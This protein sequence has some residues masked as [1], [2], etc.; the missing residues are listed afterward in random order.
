MGTSFNH[1]LTR[2]TPLQAAIAHAIAAGQSISAAARSNGVGRTAIYSW[3][4]DSPSFSK[5]IEEA[6]QWYAETLGDQLRLLSVK[7]INTLDAIL[8]DPKTS[9]GV[10]LRAAAMIL[11]RKNWQLPVPVGTP[12][13]QHMEQAL[14]LA[15]ASYR[16]SKLVQ[17]AISQAVRNNSEHFSKLDQ[18][19][20][21]SHGDP[22]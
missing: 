2:C 6:K 3:L 15:E 4:K 19:V 17:P 13:E 7:A 16:Q 8:E 18:P 20:R 11:H 10:R 9:P 1:D 22:S 21:P 5:A 14:A 12:A